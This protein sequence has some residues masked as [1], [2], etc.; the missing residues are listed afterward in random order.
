M[1]HVAS[2]AAIVAVFVTSS[3]HDVA[4]AQPPDGPDVQFPA[5]DGMGAYFGREFWWPPS[6]REIHVCWEPSAIQNTESRQREGVRA[7]IAN[8]WEKESRV[9]FVG[10]SA[11]GPSETQSVRIQVADVQ[12][13]V[14]KYGHQLQGI[15]GGVTLNFRLTNWRPESCLRGRTVQECMRCTNRC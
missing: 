3:A 10:W 7:R 13:R 9:R 15:E 1:K 14:A 8:T 4:T 6:Q 5:D 11:C 2:Y 12:P